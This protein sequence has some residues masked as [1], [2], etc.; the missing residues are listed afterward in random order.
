MSTD[1]IVVWSAQHVVQRLNNFVIFCFDVNFLH[2]G[3]NSRF[4]L[5]VSPFLMPA[6]MSIYNECLKK[7]YDMLGDHDAAGKQQQQQQQQPNMSYSSPMITSDFISHLFEHT[8]LS[9]KGIDYVLL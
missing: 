9:M 4:F 8:F 7:Q 6:S 1:L 3:C 2:R 5:S